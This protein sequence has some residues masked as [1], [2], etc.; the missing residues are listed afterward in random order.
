MK[1]AG[2]YPCNLDLDPKIQHAVSEP[3]GLEMILSVAKE[4][5]HDVELFMPA[6]EENG[7]VNGIG[8]E[9]MIEIIAEF[10]PD[11][12]AFS[13]YTCQY[14][15][16]KRIAKEL[17]R[18]NPEIVNVG[19]NRFPSFLG[20]GIEEPFDF[21]VV[22]EGEETFRELLGEIENGQ[23]YGDVRGICYRKNER[24]VF[25]GVRG[26]NFELDSLPNALRFPV[27]LN[28]VYRGISIPSLSENPHYAIM[29]Y[30]RCCYNNCNFCDNAGFWG[31][32]VSFRPPKRVVE[33]MFELKEKG[34]D[35]FYFMDLNFISH[36][37]KAEEL[38]KEMI[39]QRLDASW[40]C[41]S[42]I[43][44][45]DRKENLLRL[46]KE[47]GCYKIAWG[48]ESTNDRALERMNKK[49]GSELTTNEQTIRVLGESLRA[50]IINQG[51]YII[52]FPWETEESIL[53]DA[54]GISKMPL[55]QLGIG[56]FTP[57]PLSRFYSDM[58]KEGY[59]FD[60]DLEKHD[61]NTL[62]YNHRTLTNENIKGIQEKMYKDF[63]ESPEFLERIKRTCAID[64][65]FE[66]S[67]NDY[68]SF[69][70]K[71]ARV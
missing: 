56:I 10:K 68:F 6:R 26:R 37:G 69:F 66:K 35:V 17:K 61:R 49:V 47:A 43:G 30:S 9:E 18:R 28:Q 42:N 7:K 4:A 16:G 20:T 31:N 58:A 13:M 39:K 46:M 40:Y 12:A 52:G 14:P 36:Y 21:F 54:E 62:I 41:M 63:Y 45:A 22:K 34:V 27:I 53:K 71:D 64:E 23:D 70:G 8:E 33:E 51:F 38:C 15:M 44:A 3:Y 19:G 25:S 11:V 65:R 50:G 59:E 5:G 57:V 55:H 48:I 32:K 60:P 24:G 67:F 29:E 2:I 1:V